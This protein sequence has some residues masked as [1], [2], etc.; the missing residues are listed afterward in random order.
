MGTWRT[1]TYSNAQGG[2]CVEVANTP[3]TIGVR[4]TKQAR[5]GDAR[6]VLSFTSDAWRAF[7]DT[8]R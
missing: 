4:D 1:S 3:G 8:V 5:Q 2:S 7:L 6:T